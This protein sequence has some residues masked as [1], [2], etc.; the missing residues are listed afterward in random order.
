M[1]LARA[2]TPRLAAQ[3]C[4][5]ALF[6]ELKVRKNE[7][8][9]AG[10]ERENQELKNMARAGVEIKRGPKVMN[11]FDKENAFVEKDRFTMN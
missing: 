10:K 4:E 7:G 8:G 11:A 2:I 9:K 6:N 3:K 1:L 5:C